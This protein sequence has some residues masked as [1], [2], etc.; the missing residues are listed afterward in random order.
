MTESDAPNQ[1]A[2]AGC[3]LPAARRAFACPSHLCIEAEFKVLV[4]G[5]GAACNEQRAQ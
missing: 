1:R 2:V 5:A 4:Q 3:S